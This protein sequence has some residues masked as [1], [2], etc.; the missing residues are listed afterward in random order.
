MYSD[1]PALYLLRHTVIGKIEIGIP[2][3]SVVSAMKTFVHGL[4]L[5]PSVSICVPGI[6]F[7]AERMFMRLQFT[8]A[9]RVARDVDEIITVLMSARNPRDL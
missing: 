1:I 5:T 3:D 4:S 7:S 6:Y 8:A 9:S 2:D